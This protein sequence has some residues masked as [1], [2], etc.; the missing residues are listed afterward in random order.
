MFDNPEEYVGVND[1][2]LY[3][4]VTSSPQFAQATHNA[5]SNANFDETANRECMRH[6]YSNFMKYYSGDVFTDHLYP[7][8]KNY[9]EYMFK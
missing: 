5:N 2:G 6:M 8:A 7:T 1:E 9:T 4:S 3:G